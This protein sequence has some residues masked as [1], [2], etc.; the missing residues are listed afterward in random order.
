MGNGMRLVAERLD[1]VH[2]AAFQFLFPAGS[3]ADPVGMRGLSNILSDLMT[4]GAGKQNNREF[5]AAMD[6]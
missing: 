5:N 1:H 2:T 3:M 6:R 4:R